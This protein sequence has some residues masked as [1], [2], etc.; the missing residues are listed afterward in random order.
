MGQAPLIPID[1]CETLTRLL[2][3]AFNGGVSKRTSFIVSAS[4]CLRERKG[5]VRKET[6][7]INRSLPVGN[8]PL[9]NE[10]L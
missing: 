2:V 6:T 3:V 10:I 8:G 5:K 9:V 1:P 7:K 4:M